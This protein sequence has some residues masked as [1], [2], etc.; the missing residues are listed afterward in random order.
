ML[1]KNQKC[2]WYLRIQRTAFTTQ[3]SINHNAHPVP[4]FKPA[5]FEDNALVTDGASLRELLVTEPDNI[6]AAEMLDVWR[7]SVGM[8]LNG[9]HNILTT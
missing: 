2:Q 9:L 6:L 5:A 8:S 7:L 3:T 4:A 1:A